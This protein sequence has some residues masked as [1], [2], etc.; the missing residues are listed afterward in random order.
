MKR[1]LDKSDYIELKIEKS[2]EISDKVKESL[3]GVN[4]PDITVDL[5]SMNMLDAAKVMVLTSVYH[6]GKFPDG[7]IRC[8][9]SGNSGYNFIGPFITKNLELV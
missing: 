4:S 1:K 9:I 3:A 7:R 6:S 5:S 8:K 2:E